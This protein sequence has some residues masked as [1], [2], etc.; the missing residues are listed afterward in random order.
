MTL[1][2][3]GVLGEEGHIARRLGTYERRPEQI[4]MAVAV[5]Q[6]IAEQTHLIVEAGTGVGK[7]FA[8]LVPAILAVTGEQE[9]P[10]KPRKPLIVSTHTISLQEQLFTR[11]IPFLRQVLP[12][13]FSFVI[14]KGRSNYISLRRVAAAGERAKSTFFKEQ[15]FDQLRSIMEW[16]RKTD[17]GSKSDLTFRPLPNVWDEVASDRGNCLGKKCPTY[18]DCFYY[19]A[20]RRA[21]NADVLIVNHALFFSDLALAPRGGEPAARLRRGDL[22]RGSHAGS[23]RRLALGHFAHQRAVRLP[24]VQALQRPHA[25]RAAVHHK[26][27]ALAAARRQGAVRCPLAV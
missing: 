11:D 15:E 23:R 9:G 24:S 2:A 7:S 19:Q 20:R 1:N 22:R 21:W 27:T 17:D 18:Q 3:A 26:L 5:E 13:E 14:A 6:A 16:S 4:E 25:T 8:Y 10:N 12:N